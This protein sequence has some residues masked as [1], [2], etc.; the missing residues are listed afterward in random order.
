LFGLELTSQADELASRSQPAAIILDETDGREFILAQ[1]AKSR[2]ESS[3]ELA[4]KYAAYLRKTKA[5]DLT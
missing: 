3:H 5:L 2:G 4:V 1:L